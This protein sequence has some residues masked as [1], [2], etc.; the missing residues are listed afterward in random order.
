MNRAMI[1]F[2]AV[3]KHWRRKRWLTLRVMCNSLNSAKNICFIHFTIFR[4]SLSLPGAVL[5]TMQNCDATRFTKEFSA[6]QYVC[7]DFQ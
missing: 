3:S 6:S 4:V 7:Q 5:I 2:L 1:L